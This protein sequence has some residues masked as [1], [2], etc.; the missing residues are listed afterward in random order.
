[1]KVAKFGGT[2]LAD[3]GQIDRVCRIVTADWALVSCSWND[4]TWKAKSLGKKPLGR[5]SQVPPLSSVSHP[6]NSGR[7]FQM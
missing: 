2:S 4:S 6:V 1:M 7:C 5:P 3:A